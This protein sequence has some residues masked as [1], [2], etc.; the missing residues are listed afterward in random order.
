MQQRPPGELGRSPGGWVTRLAGASAASTNGKTARV[1]KKSQGLVTQGKVV[2]EPKP[3][4]TP[5][6][7]PF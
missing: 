2:S 7:G 3:E 1:P 4:E 6:L 5:L